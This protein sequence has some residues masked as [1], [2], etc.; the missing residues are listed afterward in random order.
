MGRNCLS[1][2]APFAGKCRARTGS[3]GGKLDAIAEEKEEG[4]EKGWY[5][6]SYRRAA[7]RSVCT[8]WI[9]VTWYTSDEEHWLPLVEPTYRSQ[10]RTANAQNVR[11]MIN[12]VATSGGWTG[13]TKRHGTFTKACITR[14]PSS[15]SDHLRRIKRN[16]GDRYAVTSMSDINQSL[17]K[18]P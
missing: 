1:L 9:R 2:Q 16:I 7:Q 12:D 4:R 11:R 10:S 8:T 13:A 17:R 14:Q 15:V 6:F 18:L 3:L 5:S